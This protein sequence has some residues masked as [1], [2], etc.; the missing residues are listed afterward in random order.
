MVNL[1]APAALTPPHPPISRQPLNHV[2]S[3]GIPLKSSWCFSLMSVSAS[4]QLPGPAGVVLG[5]AVSELTI[6][7][8]RV[9]RRPPYAHG[10]SLTAWELTLFRTHLKMHSKGRSTLHHPG[11][12]GITTS[13]PHW[14][15]HLRT[16][17]LAEPP[18]WVEG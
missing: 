14:T 12:L 9:Y 16:G 1:E 18:N 15:P 10:T 4:T 7:S 17:P 8:S 5:E 2:S 6:N 13:P 11:P 3:Q